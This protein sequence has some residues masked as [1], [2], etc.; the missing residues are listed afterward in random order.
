MLNWA[1]SPQVKKM[2]MAFVL[3]DEKL[4]DVSDRSPATRTSRRSRSAAWRE[5]TRDLHPGVDRHG[6]DDGLFGLRR[7]AARE[8]DRGIS[9][10]DLNVLIQS[11]RGKREAA[12]RG[13]LP[14]AQE[15]AARAPVPRPAGVHRAQMDAGHRR[16]P[17]G[18]EGAAA[19]DAALLRRGALDSLPMGYLLCGPVGTGKSFLAS[20]SAA[21]SA[22]RA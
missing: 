5:G 2:N 18:G 7:A 19:E 10:T 11:A 4:S 17:R 12:R 16:R 9:L 1:M 20:A 3:V 22:C 8:A 6:R 15:A 21:R 13:G 14:I